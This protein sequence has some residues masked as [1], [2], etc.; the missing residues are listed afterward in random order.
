MKKTMS[1]PTGDSLSFYIG[2]I[3]AVYFSIEV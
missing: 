1:R 3:I 2:L